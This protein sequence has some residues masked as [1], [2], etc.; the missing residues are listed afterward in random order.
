MGASHRRTWGEDASFNHVN[1]VVVVD[2]GIAYS[3]VGNEETW[4][5]RL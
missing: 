3:W 4:S 5:L 2:V 1:G